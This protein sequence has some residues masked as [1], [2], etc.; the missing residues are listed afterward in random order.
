MRSCDR[1]CRDDFR[2]IK[3]EFG[4]A[5]MLPQRARQ[6]S[7][8]AQRAAWEGNLA[9]KT[10]HLQ[11]LIDYEQGWQAPDAESK[12]RQGR[13][14]DTVTNRKKEIAKFASGFEAFHAVVHVYLL[15]SGTTMTL[16]GITTTPTLSI[17]SIVINGVITLILGIYAWGNRA[18]RL[19]GV[20]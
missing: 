18:P 4:I 9:G 10:L 17:V 20:G 7:K 15:L 1:P 6:S 16:F 5:P 8:L 3:F 11:T 13:R 14:R 19:A 12:L 2:I